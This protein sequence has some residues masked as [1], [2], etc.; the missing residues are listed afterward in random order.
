MHNEEGVRM[1]KSTFNHK[2]SLDANH[3]S[4][5]AVLRLPIAIFRDEQ[6]KH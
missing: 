6:L 1:N 4:Y 5:L 2:C 3:Y